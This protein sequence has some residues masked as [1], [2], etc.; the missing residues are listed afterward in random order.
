MYSVWGVLVGIFFIW[1]GGLSFLIW[2]QNKFLKSIFPKNGERDIRKK[3]EEVLASIKSF[4]ERLN[5]LEGK[6]NRIGSDGLKH[7][8]RVELMRFN[9][10]DDTG[11]DQSVTVALLD[12]KGTGI[13]IT[14]LHARSGTRIFAKGVI[15][16]RSDKHQFS[17]EEEKI[18]KKAMG[19]K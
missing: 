7:I 10:Y 2:Q 15:E 18:I 9:P 13:V 11:G 8:Q 12:N 3:F 4:D 14:S 19:Q 17:D 6:V 1:A 16:G 5:S